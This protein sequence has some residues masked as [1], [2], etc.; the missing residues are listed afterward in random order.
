MTSKAAPTPC[1]DRDRL[2]LFF[3]SGDLMALDHSGR[4]VW[5]RKLTEEYGPFQGNHGVG[6]SPRLTSHGLAVLVAHGG[7]CYLLS[8]EK[9]TGKTRWRTGRE[10][11][12]A[13]TTPCV[14][15]RAGREELIV[16]VNGKL[17]S[18]HAADGRSL[19][20]VNGLKGNLLASASVTGSRLVVGSSEKGFVKAFS[21]EEKEGDPPREIW[22]APNAT[23]Y[24]GS[25]LVHHGCVWLV[26]KVGV[27]WCVDLE[28]GRELWHERLAGECWASPIGAGTASFSSPSRG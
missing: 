5:W 25:P 6:S 24:F 7:P 28:T 8:V 9:A 13:W 4:T 17:E 18:Y 2:Y 10:T 3:E 23:C 14:V 12:T 20:S 19:W 11:K 27:A 15:R 1:V 26:G 22:T 16:S 21:L